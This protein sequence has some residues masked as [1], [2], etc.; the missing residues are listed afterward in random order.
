MT[1]PYIQNSQV[2]APAEN[3]NLLAVLTM[4][5]TE[6][7]QDLE[8]Y[9]VLMERRLQAMVEEYRSN[10]QLQ[11]WENLIRERCQNVPNTEIYLPNQAD[12]NLLRALAE[13]PLLQEHLSE[14]TR[15]PQPVEQDPIKQA[16]A[17]E[18]AM[19]LNLEEWL[20]RLI[21]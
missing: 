5:N 10:T 20:M 6:E 15:F 12:T 2:W 8:H 1:Q 14:V 16:R 3:A 9:Q 21:Q 4:P 17:T 7:I 19:S 11:S 13:S 18:A